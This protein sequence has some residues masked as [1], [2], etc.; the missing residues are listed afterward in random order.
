MIAA[1][2]IFILGIFGFIGLGVLVGWVLWGNYMKYY[3]NLMKYYKNLA[4]LYKEKLTSPEVIEAIL[5]K[6]VKDAMNEI[7][8][9]HKEI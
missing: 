5:K 1:I 4:E 6:R 9:K 8:K 2:I 7:C 3:K